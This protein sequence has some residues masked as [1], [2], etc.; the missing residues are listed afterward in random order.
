MNRLGGI[1]DS[2]AAFS[3]VNMIKPLPLLVF[4]DIDGVLLPFGH[5]R[6]Q[7][8]QKTDQLFPD[9]TL[10]ALDDI[11]RAFPESQVVLS[12]TWRMNP[13]F[14]EEIRKDF[15]RYA[16]KHPSNCLVRVDLTRVTPL[17]LCWSTRQHEIYEY[18]NQLEEKRV[19]W[20][21]LDDEELVDGK[22]NEPYRKHFQGKVVKTDSHQALTARDAQQAIQI[23]S[24][25]VGS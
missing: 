7:N 2:P 3:V 8:S 13:S 19:A 1:S 18:L 23:L 22:A 4:L 11:V 15:E 24:R 16:N 6:S 5:N 20:V 10:A 14:V 21:A 17:E 12:S 9:E 25:Q